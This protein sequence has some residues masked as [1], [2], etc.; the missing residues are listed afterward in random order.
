MTGFTAKAFSGGALP[1]SRRSGFNRWKVTRPM[2]GQWLRID[3]PSAERDLL[4]GEEQVKDRIR[5]LFKRYGIIFRELLAN[6]LQPLQWRAVFRSLR[7]MEL[8][9]EVLSGYFFE[10]MSGPQFISPE[11]FRMLQEPLPQDAVFWINATDSASLCGLGL[12][13]LEGLP[14]RVPSTYLVY[15]G[16]RLVMISKRLGKSLDILVTPEDGHLAGYFVLFKDMLSREFNPLQKISV[17][18]IN[19]VPALSSP[20][21]AALRQFGFKT[22]RNILELWKEF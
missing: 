10:G 6:E 11:A 18:I 12:G 7:L 16:S 19:G 1:A 21:A 2:E 9:G 8:S 15:H 22:A 17:E 20:Y 3:A 14:P 4:E 13:S 5:Q